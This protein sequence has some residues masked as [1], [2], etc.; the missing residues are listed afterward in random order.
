MRYF[1]E[2]VSLIKSKEHKK[3]FLK[4]DKRNV[5]PNILGVCSIITPVTL[6]VVS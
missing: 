1:S 2:V 5:T 6:G 4:R 3:L